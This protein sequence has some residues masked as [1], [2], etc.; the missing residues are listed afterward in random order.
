MCAF[1][2]EL[3][4]D[5]TSTRHKKNEFISLPKGVGERHYGV[6]VKYYQGTATQPDKRVDYEATVNLAEHELGWVLRLNKQQ[7]YFNRH[8]PDTIS[9]RFGA[10]VSR[11][12]YPVETVINGWGRQ[13]TGIINHPA[14]LKRW[15]TNRQQLLDKYGGPVVDDFIRAADKKIGTPSLVQRSM[16]YDLFW[17]LFFHPKYMAYTEKLEQPADLYLSVIPY[18]AP[19]RFTG[20][21]KIIPEITAY[22]SIMVQFTSEEQEAPEAL[23]PENKKGIPCFVKVNVDFDLDEEYHFAMHTRALL[24]VYQKEGKNTTI[25]VRKVEFTMYQV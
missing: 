24:E 9:E 4:F 25:P 21:Q 15:Q 10:A 1:K 8:E 12:L 22:G 19:V 6:A 11:A 16:K 3:L 20:V 18:K 17:N 13:V 7:V 5:L 14:I 2:Q 23:L